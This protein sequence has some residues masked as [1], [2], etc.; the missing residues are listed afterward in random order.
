MHEKRRCLPRAV[1]TDVEFGVSSGWIVIMGV[2]TPHKIR[3]TPYQLKE[4]R[5]GKPINMTVLYISH[6]N[7][8]PITAAWVS[9]IL[10][11]SVIGKSSVQ[12]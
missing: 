3:V 10:L 2:S 7:T 9:S 8:K 11:W 5:R 12:V 4:T 6:R 1:V